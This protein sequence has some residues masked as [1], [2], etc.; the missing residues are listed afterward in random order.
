[1][2]SGKLIIDNFAGGG[3]ASTG[4]EL[5]LGRSPDV[6]INH[7][8]EALAMHE[9]NHPW[10]RHYQS[11]VFEIDPR[12]VTRMQPVGLAW[13]S[14]DCTHH[15]KARGCKPIRSRGKKSRSLAWVVVKWAMLVKPEVMILENVEEFEDW[16]PVI[17]KTDG[18]GCPMQDVNGEP[19]YVPC[20]N[21]RGRTFKQW[22]AKLKR[23][24][25]AVEWRQLRACDYGSPTIRKR[26]F[27]IAR[28]DGRPIVWPEPTHGKPGSPAVVSGKLAPWRCAAEI[29]DW[30]LPCPSIFLT[31]EEAKPLHLKRPLAENTMKRIAAGVKRYVLDHPNPFIVYANHGGDWFR[32]R[33]VND[34]M[35]TVTASRDA[36]GLVAPYLVP[37]LGERDGQ[38]PRCR[39][40]EDP[41][42]TVTGTANGAKLVAPILSYAQQGGSNRD[43]RDPMSTITGSRKD[44]NCLVQAFLAQHNGGNVGRHPNKPLSTITQM[45]TQQQVVQASLLSHQ[46]GSNINGGD[47]RLDKPVNC[48]TTAKNVAIVNAFLCKYYGQGGQWQDCREPVHT[49][50]TVDRMGLVMVDGL[51]HQIVEIGMR[52]LTPR[53]L[54]SAQGFPA[55]YRID[56]DLNGR[57]LPKSSQV[58][59]CGN[60]VCPQLAE[61]LVRA[62]CLDLRQ[63][64]RPARRQLELRGV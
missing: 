25:Y 10:T 8:A 30:S 61:A 6:A 13:F 49:V 46:R 31:P 48:L 51:P 35:A 24:G 64:S 47:G 54:F 3:G 59:M 50:P 56:I 43:A 37:N 12:V 63:K 23:L 17:P 40:V 18:R 39:S 55:T 20:P 26:L 60:S 28:C 5:A 7:D 52:M 16:G 45:G 14:P 36:V 15:S 22:V 32:G 62:N 57:R 34:P 41:L 44:Q 4:I 29:I 33:S 58:R 21:R 2:K 11:D 9:A 53:E 27:V 38:S 1:M 19:L 42:P